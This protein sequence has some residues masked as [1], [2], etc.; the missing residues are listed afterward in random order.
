M[1]YLGDTDGPAPQLKDIDPPS[2]ADARRWLD[3]ILWNVEALLRHH[4]VHAD[5]S[6]YNL[7]VWKGRVRVID[8]PQAVDA[9]TNR[10]AR[11]LLSRD[12]EGVCRPF[13][14]WGVDV[15]PARRSA[16]LWRR[17]VSARL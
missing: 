7:L 8:L 2:P 14:R 9:R 5:L 16:D 3:R 15:D 17:Y 10:N 1:E 12:V 6:P 4:L 13:A 11:D